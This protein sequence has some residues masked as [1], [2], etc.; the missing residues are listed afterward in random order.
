MA[1]SIAS[2]GKKYCPHPCLPYMLMASESKTPN[3]APSTL[4]MK[5]MVAI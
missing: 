1:G 5:G 2:C 4:Y 3:G